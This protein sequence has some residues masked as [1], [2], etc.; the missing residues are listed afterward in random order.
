MSVINLQIYRAARM[1][2]VEKIAHAFFFELLEAKNNTCFDT[3]RDV[4]RLR[5]DTERDLSE[6]YK[7]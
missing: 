1:Y 5:F 6:F 2:A 7:V 4:S 3:Y